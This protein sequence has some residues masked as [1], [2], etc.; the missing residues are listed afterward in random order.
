MK[1]GRRELEDSDEENQGVRRSNR[2]RIRPVRGYCGEK[3]IYKRVTGGG[4]ELQEVLEMPEAE[5]QF[6][7]QK[8]YGKRGVKRER[9]ASVAPPGAQNAKNTKPQVFCIGPNG[10][11]YPV[12]NCDKRTESEVRVW[13][14]EGDCEIER[15]IAFTHR[16]MNLKGSGTKTFEFQKIFNELDYLAGG[17]LRLDPAPS[18]EKPIK[19]ARDNSYIFIVLE[20]AVE[21]TV[22]GTKF[23][24]GPRGMF[25]V[26]RGNT[27]AIKNIAQIHA[28]LFFA[29]SRRVPED[30]AGMVLPDPDT[31]RREQSMSQGGGRPRGRRGGE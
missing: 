27:Y 23:T 15:R 20:G 22:H 6:L 16:M 8:K 2:V 1:R 24:I 11:A 14:Y 13:N 10:K 5:R 31:L 17:I 25:M 29:Q 7:P 30:E 21:V 4:F 28:E 26:P 18:G 12:E 19:P 3:V 9:S